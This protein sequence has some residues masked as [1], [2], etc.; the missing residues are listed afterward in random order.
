MQ[1]VVHDDA[2]TDHMV[3]YFGATA[4]TDPGID[5]LTR[6]AVPLRGSKLETLL[7]ALR[8]DSEVAD[9]LRKHTLHELVGG[10]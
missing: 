1:V 8:Q 9:V 2:Y 7:E 4:L 5:I 6:T 3:V 10:Q